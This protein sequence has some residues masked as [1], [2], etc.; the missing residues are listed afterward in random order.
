MIRPKLTLL[1]VPRSKDCSEM[2]D[3]TM[4]GT[5]PDPLL[6][7]PPG[8]QPQRSGEGEA[9]GDVLEE[10]DL[11]VPSTLG[12]EGQ[13]EG[14]R[15]DST[16]GG[17]QRPK[18]EFFDEKLREEEGAGEDSLKSSGWREGVGEEDSGSE[19]VSR[20]VVSLSPPHEDE[21]PPQDKVEGVA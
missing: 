2:A 12:R 9:K 21:R 8:R 13:E 1:F 16:D 5:S 15:G 7:N 11:L 20:G 10:V 3:G 19:G 4:A 14:E 17:G 18:V 6:T